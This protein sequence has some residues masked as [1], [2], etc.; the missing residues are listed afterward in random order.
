[1]V[2][3]GPLMARYQKLASG[4]P[5]VVFVGAVL[6][7]RPRYFAHADV[8]ACP[9]TKASF[10]IT[11]LEAMASG[12]PIVCS[13]IVGFRDVVKH[14]REALLVPVDDVGAHAAALE[15]L[16]DDDLLARRLGDAGRAE[17]LRYAWPAVTDQVLATYIRVNAA[18][19]A[20]ERS[21]LA[22]V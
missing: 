18:A 2:G 22:T 17:A 13:D 5:D 8:Y 9:T 7:E 12:T 11:L 20:G 21:R 16:L 1:V 3:D 6:D 4:I 15:R 19:H 14:E 10:G